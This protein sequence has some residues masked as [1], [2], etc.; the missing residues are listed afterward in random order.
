[1]HDRVGWSTLYPRIVWP[2]S[3]AVR[4]SPACLATQRLVSLCLGVRLDSRSEACEV[5]QDIA[6]ACAD[7]LSREHGQFEVMEREVRGEVR[8]TTEYAGAAGG[9]MAAL[10]ASA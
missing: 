6:A 9:T 4:W 5:V 2:W 8:T 1:M 10:A 3:A 7:W